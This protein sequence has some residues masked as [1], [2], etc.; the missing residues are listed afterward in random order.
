[1]KHDAFQ[2]QFDLEIA[3]LAQTIQTSP[4][5]RQHER[6]GILCE[7]VCLH[8]LASHTFRR[9]A[10]IDPANRTQHGNRF[11]YNLR[12][13]SGHSLSGTCSAIYN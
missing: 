9:L 10:E 6:L 7:H 11:L 12:E 13:A 5:I 8:A 1:M 2:Q 3:P 4:I